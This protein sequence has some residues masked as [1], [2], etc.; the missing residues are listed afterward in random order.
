M[1]YTSN[2]NREITKEQKLQ[3][4]MFLFESE[5]TPFVK[6]REDKVYRAILEAIDRMDYKDFIAFDIMK[7]LREH[8][9]E[10]V[11]AM[12]SEPNSSFEKSIGSRINLLARK[13]I[14]EKK[15]E[16]LAIRQFTWGINSHIEVEVKG[17]IKKYIESF[18]K[19]GK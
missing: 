11:E 1:I 12:K 16:N 17:Y 19:I 15:E 8:N 3:Y 5:S 2:N 18:R 10:I 9:P 13:F 14:L 7:N 6:F 4:L